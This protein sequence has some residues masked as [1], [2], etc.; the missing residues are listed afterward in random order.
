MTRSLRKERYPMT[1]RRVILFVVVSLASC[2]SW[3]PLLPAAG[4]IDVTVTSPGPVVT[5]DFNGD[6]L[7]DF[8]VVSDPTTFVS[9]DTQSSFTSK[10]TSDLG[11]PLDG[12]QLATSGD[13]NGDGR[14]DIVSANMDLFGVSTASGSLG[15][16]S[17]S[18]SSAITSVVGAQPNAIASGDFNKDDRDDIAIANNNGNNNGAGGTI[19]VALSNSDGSF[20]AEA[21][22]VVGL[23]TQTP[24]DPS[25]IGSVVAGD[26]N[27]DDLLDLAA[28]CFDDGSVSLLI[29][30]GDGSFGDAS[31]FVVGAS[32]AMD[33]SDFNSDGNLDLVVSGLFEETTTLLLGSGDGSFES[34]T[35]EVGIPQVR[36]LAGDFSGDGK[37]D[38]I[39]TTRE[40][41]MIV[42][43]G[44]GD[45]SF[46][47]TTTTDIGLS[48]IMETGDF[49]GDGSLD[50][51]FSGG[52]VNIVTVLLGQ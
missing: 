33:I 29:G 37:P 35:I 47:K 9:G 17:G 12:F 48:P 5:G 39:F 26:F 15:D 11:V 2:N 22:F 52:G 28:L 16:R 4:F 41:T 43:T 49:N 30:N 46:T 18:F 21:R 27:N 23:P 25:R 1:R 19:S 34:R 14:L 7:Q 44:E 42:M 20:A 36:V 32:L 24:Q 50:L 3:F 38:L 8:V 13:F 6:G 45:G 10:T 31:R 51:V 40:N